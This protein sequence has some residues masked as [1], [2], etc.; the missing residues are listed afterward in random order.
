MR[1]TVACPACRD[2]VAVDAVTRASRRARC[3][4]GARFDLLPAGDDGGPFGLYR[5]DG[6]DARLTPPP[7]DEDILDL[8]GRRRTRY[9]RIFRRADDRR[10]RILRAVGAGLAGGFGAAVMAWAVAHSL[11]SEASAV[12]FAAVFLVV[13]TG[14]ASIALV[15]AGAGPPREIWLE[16]GV[17]H[18]GRGRSRPLAEIE[19]VCLDA[20]DMLAFP[21][22]SGQA[23]KF[24]HIQH[25]RSEA[26]EW[27]VKHINDGI[28]LAKTDRA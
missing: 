13:L 15:A 4:C 12:I 8:S 17:L 24:L 18:W 16:D 20:H 6:Q 19:G 14:A 22:P 25:L 21:L 23:E 26:R 28:A 9:V 5:G 27:L 1:S 11:G 3:G 2:A 10:E 7:V